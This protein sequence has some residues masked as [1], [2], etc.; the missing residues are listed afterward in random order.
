MGTVARGAGRIDFDTLFAPETREALGVED[1][2]FPERTADMRYL[3]GAEGDLCCHRTPSG[4]TEFTLR[5]GGG[6]FDLAEAVAAHF[7][8]RM[9]YEGAPDFEKVM[10]DARAA[11]DTT[12]I[13]INLTDV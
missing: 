3:A 5:G 1:A 4:D 2:P 9:T 8:T 12:T 10:H 13:R 6:A 7:R 11:G